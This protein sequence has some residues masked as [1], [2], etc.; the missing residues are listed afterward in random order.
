MK[1]IVLG[2]TGLVGTQLLELLS[3]DS[4]FSKALCPTRRTPEQLIHKMQVNKLTDNSIKNGALTDKYK[5][6]L[7]KD[8]TLFNPKET[9]VFCCLGTTIKKA[10]SKEQFRFVDQEMVLAFAKFFAEWGAPQFWM[11]SASGADANS[12][13]FYSKVKGETELALQELNFKTLGIVRPSL[14]LGKRNEFR[15]GEK[16]ATWLS[17][18]ISPFLVGSLKKYHPI[19]AR[20]VAH[21]MRTASLHFAGVKE[22]I[23]LKKQTDTCTVILENNT[24]LEI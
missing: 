22:H 5:A 13:I 11:V 16:L 19:K 21:A 10:R 12:S 7:Q 14:L 20:Q 6:E 2:A 9:I 17:P 23:Q 4:N 15:F 1:A 8:L 18:L 24:L 3:T